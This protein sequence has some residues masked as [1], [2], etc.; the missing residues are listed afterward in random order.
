MG[1]FD[2]FRGP[3]RKPGSTRT[4]KRHAH[5]EWLDLVAS[6]SLSVFRP[7]LAQVDK[8]GD[9]VAPGKIQVSRSGLEIW[10]K[11]IPDNA[12]GDAVKVGTLVAG[13][14]ALVTPREAKAYLASLADTEISA[15]RDAT[16]STQLSD[17]NVGLELMNRRILSLLVSDVN[18]VEHQ[19]AREQ[20]SAAG[21]VGIARFVRRIR[22][23][24]STNGTNDTMPNVVLDV[25]Q[26]NLDAAL[27][28][29][30]VLKGASETR[31][32]TDENVHV[33]L[34]EGSI[35]REVQ[36]RLKSAGQD[37]IDMTDLCMRAAQGKQFPRLHHYNFAYR[38]VPGVAFSD[39]HVPLGLGQ[40]MPKGAL[41]KFW[42]QVGE[43]LPSDQRLSDR[44]LSATGGEFGPHHSIVLITMPEPL[45]D[46]EAYFVAIVYPRAWFTNH[47]AYENSKPELQC[48]I[49]AKSQVPGAGGRSGG[50]LRV[51]NPDW[52][53]AIN[54][55][56]PPSERSFLDAVE[57]ALAR[58]IQCITRVERPTWK[59]FMQDAETGQTHGAI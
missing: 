33:P 22:E 56:I 30:E 12:Q 34:S 39:P 41:K 32:T 28:V 14:L 13:M 4:Q 50:T 49:L 23:H 17:E 31:A 47:T 37:S 11:N 25:I 35:A 7:T 26:R 2:I 57:S 1:I 44:G 9:Y 40:D 38:A 6:G 10:L 27:N 55:G 15:N 45:I 20:W 51:V 58:P 54:H 59:F 52:H 19:A 29:S 48:F 18:Q 21:L 8:Q 53:G 46:T 5:D 24:I 36:R 3:K 43:R 42:A 16:K